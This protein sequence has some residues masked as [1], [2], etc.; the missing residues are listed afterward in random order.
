MK[1]KFTNIKEESKYYREMEKEF[2]L[3][4]WCVQN[5]YNGS[6]VT[7]GEGA[8]FWD[9]EGNRY[10]DFSSQAMCNTLGH[11]HPKVVEA[12][13]KQA[14]QLCFVQ[15]TW[16]TI[17]RALL[18]KK[19]TEIAPSNLKKTF[20]TTGG[21][22][23]NENAIKFARMF[24]GRQKI[25]TRYRSYHGAS[26]GAMSISGDPRRWAVEPG[27]P[28][29]V[30]ALDC[31]CYR[32]PFGLSYPACNVRCV[33]HIKEL[34]ELEGPDKVCA[35]EIEPIVGSNG[36]LVPPDEYLPRLREICSQFGTLLISDE[37]MTGFGRTGAW[38][39]CQHWDVQPDIMILAKGLSAAML[40]LG[41]VMISKEI[42]DYFDDKLLFAGLTYLG[43]PMSC[44]AGVAALDV[45]HEE[46]LIEK[47]KSL[48]EYMLGCLKDMEKRHPSIGDVRGKGLFASIE[49]VKNRKTKEPMAPFN[50]GSP[51]MT[52]IGSEAKKRGVIFNIR[53][54]FFIFAPPLVISKK[55]IDHAMN[56]LDE[57]LVLADQEVN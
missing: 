11:Q 36:L 43:H 44:A 55:E 28:G 7:G 16:A 53:W 8:Y 25:I 32:C 38:F 29:I 46:N 13:R 52:K 18:A 50:G 6:V 14:E 34:I 27:I 45:Y 42:S 5:Q 26:A 41:G 22:E 10:L 37:V 49:L 9:M 57:L 17:P 54:N 1:E 19:L 24:T 2:V 48:G 47:S 12:I 33:E 3:H 51:V 39:A 20:F 30:R 23:A 15:G 31:Y 56:V 40:P 21:A 4:S 35:V